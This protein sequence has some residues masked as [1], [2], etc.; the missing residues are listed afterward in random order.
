VDGTKLVSLDL[1]LEKVSS[2]AYEAS[3]AMNLSAQSQSIIAALIASGAQWAADSGTVTE[4]QKLI[5]GQASRADNFAQRA[6]WLL[7]AVGAVDGSTEIITAQFGVYG[8]LPVVLVELDDVMVLMDPINGNLSGPFTPSSA[9]D[10][11]GLL[12]AYPSIYAAGTGV[13]YYNSYGC[14]VANGP[15]KTTLPSIPPGTVPSPYIPYIPAVPGLLPGTPTPWICT[16]T[17]TGCTCT[18][19]YHYTVPSGTPCP[20]TSPDNPFCWMHLAITCTS[21]VPCAGGINPNM[22]PAPTPPSTPSPPSPVQGGTCSESW[23]YWS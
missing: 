9:L 8:A 10:A 13:R 11:T 21:T 3:L 18:T 4:A 23:W 14:S 19:E 5:T 7:D 12:S 6:Q 17:P 2:T 22:T 1:P 15:T 20:H 16:P